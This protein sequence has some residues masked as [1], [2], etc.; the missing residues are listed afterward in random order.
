MSEKL[1][2]QLELA[3][4]TDEVPRSYYAYS[5]DEDLIDRIRALEAEVEAAINECERERE[6]AAKA[7]KRARATEC[8]YAEEVKRNTI[9][10]R[11]L[12]QH[13]RM[14]DRQREEGSDGV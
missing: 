7:N 13:A 11:D 6:L 5:G 10:N 14:I 4:V 2:D 12:R 1:S 9:L 8:D 3:D